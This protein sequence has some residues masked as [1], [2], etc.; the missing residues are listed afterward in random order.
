MMITVRAIRWNDTVK[1]EE[2]YEA[3]NRGQAYDMFK[4]DYPDVTNI[5]YVVSIECEEVGE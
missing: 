2:T 4:K 3:K 5:G 1:Y